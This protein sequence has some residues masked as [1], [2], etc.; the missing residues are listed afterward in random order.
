MEK[1]DHDILIRLDQKV[2]DGFLS[3]N[4]EM[5]LLRDGTHQR[6]SAIEIG[7]LDTTVFDTYRI[8]TDKQISA[9]FKSDAT[10]KKLVYT[11]VGILVTIQF[12]M[13]IIAT[14]KGTI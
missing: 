12:G 10:L 9:L 13:L 11:G 5:K 3:L 6:I 14:M 8:N 1:T 2:Q 4:T 7:K